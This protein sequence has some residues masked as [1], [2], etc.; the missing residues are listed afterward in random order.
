MKTDELALVVR[1]ADDQGLKLGL[2][3]ST[4][5]ME[6]GTR[7]FSLNLEDGM[8]IYLSY[9]QSLESATVPKSA[10]QNT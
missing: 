6:H 4:L 5:K 1:E 2:S 3:R 8:L 7:Y 10:K 9:N